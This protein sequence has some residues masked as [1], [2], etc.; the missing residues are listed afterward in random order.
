MEEMD[1]NDSDAPNYGAFQDDDEAN[2]CS[3]SGGDDELEVSA[4][5]SSTGL[6]FSKPTKTSTPCRHDKFA[7]IDDEFAS[8]DDEFASINNKFASKF[9]S[10]ENKF[11]SID[12]MFASLEEFLINRPSVLIFE[13]PLIFSAF[14]KLSKCQSRA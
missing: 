7:S 8:I 11:I 9:A 14:W 10:I 1:Q 6:S 3:N 2:E 5:F 12:N 4:S 13:C